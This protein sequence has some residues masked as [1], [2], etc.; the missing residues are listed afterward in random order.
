MNPAVNA[1]G[2]RAVPPSRNHAVNP[3]AIPFV[4]R[5]QNPSVNPSE[6]S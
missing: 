5:S 6:S 2:N 3:V 4:D 1:S